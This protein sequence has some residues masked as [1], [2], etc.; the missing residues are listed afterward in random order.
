MERLDQLHRADIGKQKVVRSS[1]FFE[2]S[3]RNGSLLA[4]SL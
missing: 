1:L 3:E 4:M 2:I